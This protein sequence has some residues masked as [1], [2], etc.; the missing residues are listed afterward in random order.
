MADLLEKL[1]AALADRYAI[2]REIGRG[3]MATV[4]SAEDLKHHRN[5]AV[6]VLRPE[7][8]ATLGV[9][10]FLREIEIAAGLNHPH[11][12]QLYDS[13][14]AG[15]FLYFVMPYVEQTL[16]TKLER[17]T[18]LSE[19]EAVQIT[20]TVASALDYAHK[21]NVVHR[22]IKPE[23]ILLHE[24]EPMVTDFG[25][26]RAIS[27]AGGTTLTQTGLPIGTPRYMSPE[28][29]IGSADLDGRTDIFS[30][31]IVLYEMLVGEP[32]QTPSDR[33]CVSEGRLTDTPAGH[34]RRLEALPRPIV[35][36]LSR[37]L[38]DHPADRF[39]GAKQFAKALAPP[40]RGP[41][42]WIPWQNK[43]MVAAISVALVA[44][45]VATWLLLR[46]GET[47]IV[48]HRVLVAGIQN[49]TGDSTFNPLG[50]M[51]ADRLT[52]GL[53]ETG[54]V[55]V[56]DAR[57]VTSDPLATDSAGRQGAA[58]GMALAREVGAGIVVSGAYYLQADSVQFQVQIIETESGTLLS[59]L[60]PIS[61]T[62]GSP[63][64]AVDLLQQRV[65]GSV[66]TLLDETW[67][68]GVSSPPTFEAYR[69]YTAGVPLIGQDFAGAI[70]H[71]L[72]ASALDGAFTWPLIYA[73][74][75]MV[76][77]GRFA[78][79]D[80]IIEVINRARDRLRTPELRMLDY[81]D[82]RLRGDFATAL[83]AV[84]EAAEIAPL[85]EST[86][87]IAAMLLRLNRP[88]EAIDVFAQLDPTTGFLENWWFYWRHYGTAHHMLSDHFAELAVARSGREQY[89]DHLGV[90]STEVVALAALGRVD[91]LNQ[92]LDEATALTPQA[93]FGTQMMSTLVEA[94][95]E[96][97]SHGE[98]EASAAVLQRLQ[99]WAENQSE[100]EIAT[101]E[102]RTHLAVAAYLT[103]RW[104][105][106]RERFTELANENPNH[107][108]FQAYLG[109]TAARLGER[110]AAVA[111][112]NWLQQLEQPYLFGVN[113]VWQARIA[114]LLDEPDRAVAL[115][116]DAFEQGVGHVGT[117]LTAWASRTS[118]AWLHRDIDLE[119]LRDHTAF[120]ELLKPKG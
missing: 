22:D 74:G 31:G 8:A 37:A 53:E 93:G 44:G 106:A 68:R 78:Q 114:A 39:G 13:G 19:G 14:E 102:N 45:S 36:A 118:G 28:Q 117:E 107:M 18:Q 27:A 90:L 26:A 67:P 34:R 119:S 82:A 57:V 2:D 33:R 85:S 17:E 24:G 41:V 9:E 75:L 69:E 80:S 104:N 103:R 96:L 55:E 66:A 86:W 21:H 84:Q 46:N 64:E 88:Q 94:A 113:T 81:L 99:D 6:K 101:T 87:E 92:R 10:R 91:Q 60:D 95:E 3:G 112:S 76:E 77:S 16:R 32:P 40:R 73:T 7:L 35:Q 51:V 56:V 62:R 83:S 120:Q 111:I 42:G 49:E 1:K 59:S 12:L 100:D 52:R 54:L 63:L 11:I 105:D 4:F 115:L 98:P 79:A 23:N 29:A 71:F 116:A 108:N 50:K 109:T 38:A 47:E 15:G 70:D 43:V 65:M 97:R 30:L 89:P 72:Q 110:E 61:G 25:I 48:P 58:L 20:R 5:V